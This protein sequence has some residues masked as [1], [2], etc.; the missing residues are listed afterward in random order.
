VESL[1]SPG[2]EVSPLGSEVGL[3]VV[4]TVVT[5]MVVVVD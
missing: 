3:M 1:E 5:V 4:G 2:S